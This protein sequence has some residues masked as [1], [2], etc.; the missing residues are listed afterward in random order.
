MTDR[1]IEILRCIVRYYVLNRPQIQALCFQG[2]KTGRSTRRRLQA[3]V[4]AGLINRH[5]AE[6][7][8]PHTGSAGSVYYPADRGCQLLSEIDADDRYL[9]TPTQCPQAHH[10]MHWL[11]VSDTQI[12]LNAAIAQQDHVSLSNWVNEWDIVNKDEQE[13]AKRFRLYSLIQEVPTRLVCAPDAGIVLKFKDYSKVFYLEQDRSTTGA[14]QVA[15]R[16]I[17]GYSALQQLNMHQQQFPE[18]NVPSLTV[19]CI[20]PNKGRRDALR[21]AF[22][23]KPGHELWKFAAA[24][25]LTP[26]NMLHEPLFYPAQGD[27]IPMIKNA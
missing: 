24:N 12:K 5:R 21:R 8:Y 17:K 18:V 6:V 10:V 19:L 25:E 9:L 4:K 13:P 27:P 23:D 26:E 16:K 20:A 15:A 11:A 3:L 7:I 2:D 14:R 22:V 1:D